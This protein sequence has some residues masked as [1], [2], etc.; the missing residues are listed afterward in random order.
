MF[1]S[2]NDEF[3]VH[4][5]FSIPNKEEV[6]IIALQAHLAIAIRYRVLSG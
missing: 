1:S 3:N 4:L 5:C 2:Q 6:I